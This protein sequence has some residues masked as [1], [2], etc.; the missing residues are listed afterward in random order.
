[1]IEI[2]KRAATYLNTSC[3]TTLYWSL[4]F[5]LFFLHFVG[6]WYKLCIHVYCSF[7]KYFW[8]ISVYVS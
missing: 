3:C 6:I 7:T 1:L 4:L 8:P 2:K 5:K